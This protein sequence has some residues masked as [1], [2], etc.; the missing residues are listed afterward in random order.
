MAGTRLALIALFLIP[1]CAVRVRGAQPQSKEDL[2][3]IQSKVEAQKKAL[4][5]YKREEKDISRYI[6]FLK[7]QDQHARKMQA[8][9]S[10]QLEKTKKKM[11]ETRQ[12]SEAL[13]GSLKNWQ[14]FFNRETRAAM[15]ND[16]SSFAYYGNG[17]ISSGLAMRAVMF[18]TAGMLGRLRGETV[19]TQAVADTLN[20]TTKNLSQQSRQLQTEQAARKQQFKT[21]MEKLQDTRAKYQAAMKELDDLKNSAQSM[22]T[23]LQKHESRRPARERRNTSIALPIPRNSMPWPAG[24]DVVNHFGREYVAEIKASISRDGITIAAA[25]G[26]EVKSVGDGEVIYAGPFRSYGKVVI[27]DHKKGYFT[28]YGFLDR[29]G[30]SK[31]DKV[32]AASVLGNAGTDTRPNLSTQESGAGAVYFEIRAGTSAVDPERWLSRR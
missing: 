15:L 19:K 8:N 17:R 28:I 12:R 27:V 23:F 3:K 31:G 25:R 29:I 21:K 16:L 2:A 22:M 6:D 14:T 20:R 30:V 1:L 9:I 11:D 32:H 7:S 5:K 4:E 18:K 26:S 13:E 10:G 24:G